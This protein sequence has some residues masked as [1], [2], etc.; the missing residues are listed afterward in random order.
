M[1][2]IACDLCGVSSSFAKQDIE[3][4]AEHLAEVP[5]DNRYATLPIWDQ[6]SSHADSIHAQLQGA[7]ATL[8][9]GNLDVSGPMFSIG[10][11]RKLASAWSFGGFVFDDPLRIQS[12]H[13]DRPL[14]TLF[15]PS[16]PIA[17]PID[18]H[19]SNLN[20]S[21]SD[22]GAGLFFS[23]ESNANWLGDYAW[24]AGVMWQ[25]IEL[26]DFRLDYEV[27]A[28]PAAGVTGQ[29]DFDNTYT[30]VV[31]F[32]GIQVPRQRGAWSWNAHA[33]YAMPLPRRGVVG[34]ITGPGFDIRGD[35]Q[36]VGNGKHFGDPSLTL[37]FTIAYAPAHLSVDVG[38]LLSQALLEGW[39][40]RGI[41]RD[42]VLSVN[43]QWR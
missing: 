2:L 6:Q 40:H 1:M 12:S 14:R 36:D 21:V 27:D 43:W 31:P 8:G 20:G 19:F 30:H 38:T 17:Q 9:S 24:L 35:T 28:G 32:F 16:T 29:I 33:L 3:F 25:R 23:E 22:V 42:Y 34:H 11:Q 18:A 13:E 4:V 7:Y 39:I 26:K 10:L 5:M 15:A 37:G 41:E